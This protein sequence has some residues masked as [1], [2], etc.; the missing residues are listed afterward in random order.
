MFVGS[1]PHMNNQLTLQ[2]LGTYNLG[3]MISVL[4]VYSVVVCQ[5][6]VNYLLVLCTMSF[7]TL[8]FMTL[9]LHDTNHMEVLR[10]NCKQYEYDI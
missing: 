7:T 9:I 1:I 10:I 5:L 3:I 6:F 4:L 2:T 8:Y